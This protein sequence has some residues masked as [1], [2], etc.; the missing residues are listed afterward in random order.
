MTATFNTQNHQDMMAMFEK[1]FAG[2]GRLDREDKDSWSK[3][4]VYQHGEM[5]ELF[6]A[7]RHGVAYG[8]AVSQ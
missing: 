3:G 7:F 6:K 1:I 4:A 8:V 2:R 5:N